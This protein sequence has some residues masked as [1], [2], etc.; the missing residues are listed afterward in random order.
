M[1]DS[2]IT[3][4]QFT[5]G[6]CSSELSGAALPARVAWPSMTTG[7]KHAVIF[8]EVLNVAELAVCFIRTAYD[9]LW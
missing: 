1:F 8:H 6:F 9:S 7:P 3:R 4:T 5:Y 2:H